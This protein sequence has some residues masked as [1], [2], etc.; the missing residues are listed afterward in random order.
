VKQRPLDELRSFQ[1]PAWVMWVWVGWL[2]LASPIILGVLTWLGL[3]LAASGIAWIVV[4][5]VLYL[6]TWA[7][8]GVRVEPDDP[9]SD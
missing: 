5:A 4:T 2:L 7:R 9:R 1:F 6:R 8:Y 3:P